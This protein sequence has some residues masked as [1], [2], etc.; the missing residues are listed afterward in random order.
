MIWYDWY[1]LMNYK[2]IVNCHHKQNNFHIHTNSMWCDVRC[3]RMSIKST[4]HC[5][6]CLDNGPKIWGYAEETGKRKFIFVVTCLCGKFWLRVALWVGLKVKLKQSDKT[7]QFDQIQGYLY[8]DL[9]LG[10][11]DMILIW[12]KANTANTGQHHQHHKCQ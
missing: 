5:Q 12:I 9:A 4:Q 11:F 8:I 3:E 1:D 2:W 6:W 7:V 10:R